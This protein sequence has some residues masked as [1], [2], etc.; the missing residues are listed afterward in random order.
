[1]TS[2]I[3]MLYPY[4]PSETP[5]P[6]TVTSARKTPISPTISHT[7]SSRA[8]DKAKSEKE[9]SLKAA[10]NRGPQ[11]P[12]LPPR[13]TLIWGY[14]EFEKIASGNQMEHVFNRKTTG[15]LAD[16]PVTRN[17]TPQTLLSPILPPSSQISP[18]NPN[19]FSTPISSDP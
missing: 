3:F 9:A 10:R 1:M 12:I 6:R 14:S 15:F 18:A 16:H 19:A 2:D 11:L 4:L 17:S 13:C 7:P 8:H 5:S